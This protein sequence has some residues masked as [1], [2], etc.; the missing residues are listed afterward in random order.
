MVGAGGLILAFVYP[1]LVR[2]PTVSNPGAAAMCLPLAAVIREL[3][4]T[5]TA[6][7]TYLGS[8]LQMFIQGA[9]IAWMP[10]YL[11]R[12][13]GMDMA[14]SAQGAGFLVLIAGVGMAG[15]GVLVDRLSRHN[16]LN[17]LRIPMF[18]ALFSTCALLVAFILPAGALQVS[19]IGLG[20]LLSAGFAGPAGAV[21]SDVT[22]AS[23]RASALATL[24]LAN[25]ILGL[26]PG[27]FITG[28]LAD[29]FDLQ[30][31]LAVVPLV[32][33]GA[34]FAYRRACC[35]YQRDLVHQ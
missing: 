5:R 19:L 9:V 11:N 13:Y 2:E 22:S 8:G 16:E 32:G 15:G 28:V 30:M 34:A 3:L 27:P 21:I 10:S 26:A 33:L 7:W 31:A 20:L 35:H 6:L 17:K 18:Y 4:T 29:A 1:L 12:F 14:Q 24:V 25:N 23:I